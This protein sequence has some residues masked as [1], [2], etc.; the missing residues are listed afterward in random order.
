MLLMEKSKNSSDA[1]RLLDFNLPWRLT[2]LTT[3]ATKRWWWAL[4]ISGLTF[5]RTGICKGGLISESFSL[6][7][8]PPKKVPNHYPEHFLRRIV[9]R[10]VIWN[11]FWVSFWKIA[12]L[13]NLPVHLVQDLESLHLIMNFSNMQKNAMRK[14]DLCV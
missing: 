11:I 8:H 4:A 12:T 2:T 6:W 14:S 1:C 7:L 13:T 5:F 9:L 10:I 3:S